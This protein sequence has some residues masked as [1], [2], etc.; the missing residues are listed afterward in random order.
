MSVTG[1]EVAVN[2]S[3]KLSAASYRAKFMLSVDLR[4]IFQD[5]PGLNRETCRVIDHIFL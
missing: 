5:G 4:I 1:Y 2:S 3:T